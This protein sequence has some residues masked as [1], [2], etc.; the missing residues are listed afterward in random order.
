MFDYLYTNYIAHLYTFYIALLSI[1]IPIYNY[2]VRPLVNIL[3]RQATML[4]ISFEILCIDDA[5]TRTELYN[6]EISELAHVSYTAL[7]KNIG[8]A[9]IR[10]L[11]AQQAQYDYLLFMD[12]DMLPNNMSFLGNYIEHRDANTVLCGGHIYTNERPLDVQCVLHWWYGIHREQ[13]SAAVRQVNAYQSFMPSNFFIP[14]AIF[15]TIRFD[16][17]LTQYG[18]EDTL[19]GIELAR[20]QIKVVHLDNPLLHCHLETAS[21]FLRKTAQAVENLYLLQQRY[22]LGNHIKLLNAFRAVQRYKIAFILALLFR[23]CKPLLLWQLKSKKPNLRCFDIY[24]L[25]YMITYARR[26]RQF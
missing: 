23:L 25:G 15:L 17:S 3:H 4:D 6:E 20:R 2:D 7:A 21:I 5:S 10:N 1:L 12:C 22:E 19:F 18:H 14:R 13:R 9:R 11:L 16:G 8:R 24:K 26:Q